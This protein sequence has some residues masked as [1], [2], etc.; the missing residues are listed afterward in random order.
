M[1]LKQID[2]MTRVSLELEAG[3][4]ADSMDITAGVEAC[5]MIYGL[6]SGGLTAFEFS[7]AGKQ[8]GDEIQLH[9]QTADMDAFFEHIR[10]P[11]L[12]L[13]GHLPDFY[14]RVRIKDIQPADS[15]EVI[16]ALAEAADCGCSC[17]G[18]TALESGDEG[19][20]E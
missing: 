9:I 14:L 8:P 2:P 4:R 11:V 3:R 1:S 17:C 18:H 12:R 16:K 10:L 13:V 15:R 7:L 20:T 19:Q 6:G 5:D